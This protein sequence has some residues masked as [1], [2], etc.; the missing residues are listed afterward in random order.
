MDQS[1][2]AIITEIKNL[3]NKFQEGDSRKFKFSKVA[4]LGVAAVGGAA[5][6]VV[7]VYYNPEILIEAIPYAPL[8]QMLV[9]DAIL[10]LIAA[11]SGY[12]FTNGKKETELLLKQ[13]F[14]RRLN[15][16][17][18]K[19]KSNEPGN[20]VDFIFNLE[21]PV[22]PAYQRKAHLEVKADIENKRLKKTWPTPFIK[23][24]SIMP[25][26]MGDYVEK[27]NATFLELFN[28]KHDERP[29]I[30]TINIS[31][32][33]LNDNQFSD[34]LAFGLGCC[35]TKKLILSH[36]RLDLKS[37]QNLKKAIQDK[38]SAFHDL[39]VLDLSYNNLPEEA[40]KEI[41]EIVKY[42]GIDELN[43][44][45]N[46]FNG[47][48]SDVDLVS[49]LLREFLAD[50]ATSMPSLKI[51]KLADIN[52]TDNF[53]KT[54][55]FMILKPSVLSH[56]DITHNPNLRQKKLR[57]LFEKGYQLN[58]SLRE[59]LVDGKENLSVEGII[60]KKDELYEEM[61]KLPNQLGDLDAP[62]TI[63]LLNRFLYLT[64]I[65]ADTKEFLAD[66][67]H[68]MV[69]HIT[70]E[71]LKARIK[72]FKITEDYSIPITEKEF[73]R[74]MND[75]LN[76]F[77]ISIVKGKDTSKIDERLFS[78]EERMVEIK[79]VTTTMYL[80]GKEKAENLRALKADDRIIPT[81]KK[82]M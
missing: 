55:N 13:N 26:N 52:L 60:R 20:K 23:E 77:Y 57:R 82:A 5:V 29:I 24:N 58:Q 3:E 18:D 71:I 67:L 47:N 38:Q 32:A 75:D 76:D 17:L 2:K 68:K 11:G 63:Y 39:K 7:S 21:S 1:Q 78:N 43:I 74:F 22:Y 8:T 49:E 25:L 73:I 42:L 6:A 65:K 48:A 45:G 59:L 70:T 64:H 28:K 33:E 37:V 81:I 61:K 69:Q 44:S 80:L 36:N 10:A 34:M 62:R 4:G 54:L 40:L 15:E 41:Q 79:A 14:S 50:Q 72:L 46:P 53:S 31:N 51:L 30:E 12:F 66:P 16:L 35:G 19:L 27:I 56:L 9:G